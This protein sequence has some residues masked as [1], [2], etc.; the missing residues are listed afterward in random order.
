MEERFQEIGKAAP[1]GMPHTDGHW[2]QAPG[3]EPPGVTEE[4][5]YV[6]LSQGSGA[7]KG[8]GSFK[9]Y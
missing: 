6:P 2:G 4:R 9:G 5:K 3:Y 1:W 8:R 7:E